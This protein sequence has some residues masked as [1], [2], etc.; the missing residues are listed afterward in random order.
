MVAVGGTV[1]KFV[2]SID[3]LNV[4][5]FGC[6]A[7]A[8]MPNV[9]LLVRVAG[10]PNGFGLNAAV[11]VTDT[12]AVSGAKPM[13][14][15]FTR[16]DPMVTPVTWGLA[17]GTISPAG[18]NTLGVIVATAVFA[19]AK[20]IVRPPGGAANERLMGKLPDWPGARTGMAPKL[21]RL[22]VTVRGVEALV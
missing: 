11:T 13:A 2:L 10:T 6:G 12:F 4:I 22:L 3:K 20:L 15:A 5:P 19:L 17:A 21:M 9:M 18:T 14:V 16:V 7:G 1:A 8:D